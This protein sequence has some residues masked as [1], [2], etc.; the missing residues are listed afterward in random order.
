M[1]DAVTSMSYNLQNG[2]PWHGKGT[3]LP[4]LS[5]SAECIKAAGLDWG[6]A[7][8]PLRIADDG[9]VPVSSV[10][11]T[12]RMDFAA[13]DPRRVLGI[14]GEEYRPLQNWDAFGFFDGVVGAG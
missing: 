8:V 13:T 4:G 10:M 11:A 9:Q 14:V 5:T 1:P 12:V 7:K 2:P 6:V 3:A